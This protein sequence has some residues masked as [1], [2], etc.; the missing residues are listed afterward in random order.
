MNVM[1]PVLTELPKAQEAFT[2]STTSEAWLAV[3]T[4]DLLR[5][6][7]ESIRECIKRSGLACGIGRVP[8]LLLAEKAALELESLGYS[9]SVTEDKPIQQEDGSL[10]PA[11]K[12]SISF[13][14]MPANKRDAWTV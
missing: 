8:G 5:A 12:I 10:M 2:Q 7:G 1:N 11:C 14:H 9:T 13:I 3:D 4:T 6:C